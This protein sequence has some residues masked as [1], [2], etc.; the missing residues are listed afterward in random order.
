MLRFHRTNP[1]PLLFL[2]ISWQGC[3]LSF[4]RPLAGLSATSSTAPAPTTWAD[5]SYAAPKAAYPRSFAIPANAPSVSGAGLSFSISPALPTGL[6]LDT[7]NGVISGT[8]TANTGAA[9]GFSS[10]TVTVTYPDATTDTATVELLVMDGYRVDSTGA[11]P[12]SNPGNGTCSTAGGVCTLQ[13]AMDEVE[14]VGAHRIISLP[15]G[16]YTLTAPLLIDAAGLV[17]DTVVLSGD[18]R[19]GTILDGGGTSQLIVV[20]SGINLTVTQMTL[21]NGFNA[22]HGAGIDFNAGGGSTG[23]LRIDGVNFLNNASGG[24]GGAV[25]IGLGPPGATAFITR[26]YFESN[27]STDA[28]AGVHIDGGTITLTDSE[29][30]DN[31]S[32]GND[33]GGVALHYSLSD[34][35]RCQFHDNTAATFGG[36]MSVDDFS[37][38]TGSMQLTDLYFEGN[39]AA[40]GAGLYFIIG[41]AGSSTPVLTNATFRSNAA[42][43]AGGGIAK[44]GS[45]LV[46]IRNVTLLSNT[47]GSR[48]GGLHV[49]AGDLTVSYAT[50]VGNS[51]TT[52]GGGIHV[53]A[54]SLLDLSKSLLASNGDNCSSAGTLNSLGYNV[55]TTGTNSCG[56][57]VGTDVVSAA[58]P[59]VSLTLADN[60]G[61]IETL[62]LSAGSPAIDLIPSGSCVL[63]SDARGQARPNGAGCDAGA[64]EY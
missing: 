34:I 33:G 48:G 17:G 20:N 32:T 50:L 9:P 6:S 36:G 59:G 55:L 38:V 61:E 41:N 57:S 54:G 52:S 47:A 62:A 15:D 45:Q 49:T 13:A 29:F 37:N 16:T 4:N 27:S 23:T 64:Y 60:G 24:W 44:D 56:T 58:T 7:T 30:R 1:L 21:Q 28:G 22:T 2:A 18:S 43:G 26:S 8:P 46:E 40:S 14:A 39:E 5:L 53:A 31:H 51:A 3:A 12:D 35:Q 19:A 11:A 10:Y 42:T 25:N 63:A